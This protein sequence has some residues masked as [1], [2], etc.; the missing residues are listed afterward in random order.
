MKTNK[1]PEY[2]FRALYEQLGFEVVKL[3]YLNKQHSELERT[4]PHRLK[5]YALVY[6][7]KGNGSHSIDFKPYSFN[8][9]SLLFISKNQVHAWGK[10]NNAKGFV[11]FFT[12]AFLY[13]N[14]IQFNDLSYSYPYNYNL[15]SPVLQTKSKNTLVFSQLIRRVNL[16]NR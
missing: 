12:E 8:A 3:E 4:K 2:N 13:K 15:Y 6:I 16:C 14:Q 9:G 5:F 7:T 1:I 10:N 11:I